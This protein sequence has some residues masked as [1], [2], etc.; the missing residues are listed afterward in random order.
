MACYLDGLDALKSGMVGNIATFLADL[1][2]IAIVGYSKDIVLNI[3]FCYDGFNIAATCI[4]LICGGK[5][6]IGESINC[7]CHRAFATNFLNDDILDMDEVVGSVRAQVKHNA[8][9]GNYLGI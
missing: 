9:L 8:L 7:F 3:L 2:T 6:C 4:F 5:I 1:D